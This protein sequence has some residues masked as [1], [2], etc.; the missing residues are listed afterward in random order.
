MMHGVTAGCIIPPAMKTAGK[1]RFE[2]VVIAALLLSSGA[3]AESNPATAPSLSLSGGFTASLYDSDRDQSELTGVLLGIKYKQELATGLTAKFDAGAQLD[4]GSS[5]IAYNNDFA[6]QQR[7]L[8]SEASLK[9][10]PLAGLDFSAGTLNQAQNHSSLLL[11]EV[12][13]PGAEQDFVF[14]PFKGAHLGVRAEEAVPTSAMLSPLVTESVGMPYFFAGQVQGGYASRSFDASASFGGFA[15]GQLSAD[16][17][18]D[19]RFRGNTVEGIGSAGAQFVYDYQGIEAQYRLGVAVSS[20]ATL[21]LEG[22]YILNLAAP[23]G[24]NAGFQTSL[25][26]EFK[27]SSS[28]VITPRFSVFCNES[29]SSP[30]LYS[31]RY[32][33]HN[34]VQG[35]SAGLS[36]RIPKQQL[37]FEARWAWATVIDTDP[38]Q[39]DL[40]VVIFRMVKSYALF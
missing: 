30:A 17:A 21:R 29:D 18:Q 9:W 37:S 22:S 27:A 16:V 24:Q 14:S 38:Y 33:G 3:L 4:T 28:L 8:L 32:I 7:L 13:F 23:E 39:S 26:S 15:F 11:S 1:L 25:A 19:S 5:Q 31:D 40:N 6:P 2:L 10:S 34:N 35:I 12:A 20:W 36:A